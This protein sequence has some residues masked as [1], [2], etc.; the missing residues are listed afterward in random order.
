[1]E[2][3]WERGVCIGGWEAWRRGAVRLGEGADVVEDGEVGGMI[4]ARGLG[5]VAEESGGGLCGAVEGFVFFGADVV[6]R[7]EVVGA[8]A[9]VAECGEELLCA[10]ARGEVVEVSAAEERELDVGEI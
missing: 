3:G 9:G 2:G 8:A 10:D 7:V 5:G 6:G 1:M 4:G